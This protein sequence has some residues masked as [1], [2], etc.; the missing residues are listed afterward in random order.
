[1]ENGFSY[2]R[3]SK[4]QHV[5]TLLISRP[6]KSNAFNEECWLELKTSIE[7]LGQDKDTR[8]IILKGE[9]KNFSAGMDLTTLMGIP[10]RW[11]DDCEARKRED[12]AGFI[13]HIQECISSIEHCPVPVIA[14][15]HGA[16]IGGALSIV[17]ACDMRYC[18]HDAY[19]SVRETLLGIVADIGVLQR[20]PAMIDPG[21]MAELSYTGRNFYSEEA[22]NYG[23]V[24]RVYETKEMLETSVEKLAHDIASNSPLVIRGIKK[25]LL[26]RRDHST[27]EALDQIALYNAAYLLS[28]DLAEAMSAYMQKRKPRFG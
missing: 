13:K 26:Y 18:S 17:T 23:L 20:M 8:V 1:M 9:G 12:I 5:S 10:G 25:A 3:I 14:C 4:N 6:D 7:W 2:F 16:C 28:K 19:F 22:L 21:T 11:Q 27:D 24:T 15:I